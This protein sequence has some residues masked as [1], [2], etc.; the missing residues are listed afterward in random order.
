[1]K[2]L[3]IYITKNFL[4]YFFYSLFSFLAI[5]ILSQIF[6]VLRYVNE[7]QLSAGEV[8]FFIGNLLPGIII[9][10]TPLSVLLGGLISINIMA[11]NLEIISLK[12]AGIRFS[13]LV[14]GPILMSFFRSEEHTSELQSRQYLVCRLLLEKKKITDYTLHNT[15][16]LTAVDTRDEASDA[17]LQS[18]A[19]VRERVHDYSCALLL[20][21]PRID[22]LIYRSVG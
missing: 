16:P 21:Y 10:V 12:T 18:L 14:R 13:R 6:K 15:T 11:S 20:D 4:K 1:M 5:F 19:T 2:K 9:N 3:D 8:P 7:G 17:S 22:R